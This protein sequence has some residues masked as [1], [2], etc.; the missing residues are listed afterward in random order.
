MSAGY[1]TPAA[2]RSDL[3]A[4]REGSNALL[5]LWPE[6]PDKTLKTEWHTTIRTALQEKMS[7][8]IVRH[9]VNQLAE[10]ISSRYMSGYMVKWITALQPLQPECRQDN[11]TLT[12]VMQQI[13]PLH[14]RV[15]IGNP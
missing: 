9:R 10:Y 1:E 15:H 6:V 7:Y 13:L 11:G 2:L 5:H 14:D 8:S 12:H 4:L 3:D